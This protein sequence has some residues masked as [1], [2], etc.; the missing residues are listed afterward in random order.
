MLY[1]PS[2]GSGLMHMAW[3]ASLRLVAANDVPISAAYKVNP[4]SG[5][6]TVGEQ[7]NKEEREN[8]TWAG[9]VHPNVIHWNTKQSGHSDCHEGSMDI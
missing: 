9:N 8:E 6:H 1:D 3:A 5:C 4:I 2:G 7:E